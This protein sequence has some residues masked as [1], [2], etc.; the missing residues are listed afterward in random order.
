MTPALVLDVAVVRR[1]IAKMAKT[2]EALG[3]AEL[4]PAY[5]VDKSPDLARMQV[6]A[7][8]IGVSVATVWEA[9]VMVQA[10]LDG[11]FLVNT[12]AGRDKLSALA[13]IARRA[14][15]M[16]AVDDTQNAQAL[17]AAAHSAGSTLGVLIEVDTGMDRAGVDT[18]E[19]AVALAERLV[20]LDGLQLIRGDWVRRALFTHARSRTPPRASAISDA[21]PLQAA[22]FIRAAGLPCEIVSQAGPA[23]GIGPLRS[24]G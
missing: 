23:L 13:T 10:G 12:V 6:A 4:R 8:A 9:M 3:S 17:A 15:V 2:L 21:V 1:N 16:V 11:A 24:Q 18:P 22:E 19:E 14:E 20:Q 7:G 5:Q